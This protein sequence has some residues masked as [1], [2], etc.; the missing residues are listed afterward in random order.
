M[1]RYILAVAIRD[2]PLIVSGDPI[3][4][5][6]IVENLL[7]NACKFTAEGGKIAL[8]MHREGQEVVLSV[9]DNGMGI[10]EEMLTR[11]FELFMQEE[12]ASRKS[13]SGLGIGL[14]L[15]HQLVSLHGGSVVAASRGPGHG[16]KFIVRLP[17][18]DTGAGQSKT[19]DVPPG[20][21]RERI[22]I[23]DD[24]AD[25]AD[26][27]AMLM[28][29]YGYEV[30]VAYDKASAVS[31]AAEFVPHLALLDLSQPEPDGIEIARQLQQ[32]DKTKGTVL[33]AFSGYG[34]PD[35][36]ERT[37]KAGFTHHLVKP[38]DAGIIHKLITSMKLSGS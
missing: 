33:V 17:L 32:M 16:S 28:E 23:V 12:R 5:T 30:R 7:T 25:S 11:I 15:V 2:E 18:S 4:L 14:S 8:D 27:M 22:L 31:K 13:S 21:G 10:P 6:Q 34:Q 20:P 36:M 29:T 26:S 24:N 1:A 19:A 37:R 9:E 35:D 3:R 38:V